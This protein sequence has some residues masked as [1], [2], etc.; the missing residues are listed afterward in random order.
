MTYWFP[1]PLGEVV[2]SLID[3]GS[4][5][6]VPARVPVQHLPVLAVHAAA[7]GRDGAADAARRLRSAALLD[8]GD[9]A[10]VARRTALHYTAAMPEYV[11]ALDQGTSSS[12]AILFDRARRAG[13][14]GVAGV[15]ADLPAAGLGVARSGGDLVVAAR[16]GAQACSRTRGRAPRTS[17]RSAS[18]TSARRRSSGNG[19]PARAVAD[20]VVWQCRRTAGIC[21]ELRARG[22]EPEVRARTGLLIDAYFSGTKVRWL[23]DNAAAGMQQRAEAGELAFGTVDSWLIHK[24]TGGRDARHRRD[25]RIADDAVQPAR[26]RL[27]RAHARRA[28]RPARDAAARSSTAAASSPRPTR[29]SSDARSRSPASPA[30]SRP[31]SSGRAASRRAARRTRTAPA[32]SSCNTPATDASVLRA[33]P[34][35]DGRVAH[36][37]RAAASRSKAA[38]SSPAR[39]CS[40]C[41]TGSGSSRRR[42]RARRSPRSVPSSGGVYVVPAFAGLGAPHWDPYARG[43]IVGITRGTTAA[44]I[45]ARHA[46]GDRA[47]DTDVVELM[48]RETG[49]RCRSCASTAARRQRSV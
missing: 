38:S 31:R 40:G 13:G 6:R 18:R 25:E 36:R 2:T 20:A 17:P 12:R 33:R 9:E 22:L 10:G 5:H 39:R 44:H 46:G 43:T 21:E 47:A 24:L 28:A 15:P 34:A 7:A 8:Q 42:P 41:A 32:A 48:E 23:L 29:R 19:R 1:H 14:A 4:A 26:R 16:S 11:L 27:G 45:C 3:A 30:T 35:D 49:V 37:R